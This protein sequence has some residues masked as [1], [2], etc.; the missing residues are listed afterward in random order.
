[1][2]KLEFEYHH[3]VLLARFFGILTPEDVLQFD[4]AARLIVAREG[5]LRG[6]L[7]Y[8]DIEIVAVPKTLL[9]QRARL[10]QISPGQERVLVAAKPETYEM[11][12]AYAAQQ[13]DFGNV[14]PRVVPTLPDAYRLL[15]LDKPDFQA[16]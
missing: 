14:E 4:E 12:R 9:V 6:I 7:D 10:P 15:G 16:I 1:M 3:R 2:F 13:R 8:S 11:A 5:P